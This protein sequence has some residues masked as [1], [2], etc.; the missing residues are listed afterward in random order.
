MDKDTYK[1]AKAAL[2][3]YQDEYLDKIRPLIDA[4]KHECVFIIDKDFKN[5][6][7]KIVICDI[8]GCWYRYCEALRGKHRWDDSGPWA[9]CEACGESKT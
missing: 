7:G 4:M 9:M 1:A 3:K 5:C 2:D 8:C 6:E